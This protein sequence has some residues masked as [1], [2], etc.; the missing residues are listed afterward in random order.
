[1][2]SPL[3]NASLL[4]ASGKGSQAGEILEKFLKDNPVNFDA[5]ALLGVI[6]ATLGDPATAI[7]L[8]EKADRVRPGDAV[9]QNN[10]AR[11]C[12]QQDR[13]DEA[14]GY[15][16]RSLEIEPHNDAC[17]INLGNLLKNNDDLT[18]AANC[19]KRSLEI[20]PGNAWV[21]SNLG[22]VLAARG[23][24]DDAVAS[25]QRALEIDSSNALIHSNLGNAL[26]ALGR[27]DDAVAAHQ[28]ALEIDPGIA[29]IHNNLGS[30]LETQ[31]LLDE[32]VAS[33]RRALEINPDYANVSYNL[34]VVYNKL[35]RLDDA[36]ASYHRALAIKPD[37]APA[38]NNLGNVLQDLGR[39]DEGIFSLRKALAIKPDYAEAH[40][41]LHAHLLDPGDMTAAIKCMGKAV[42]IDPDRTDYRFFLGMLLDYSG[43][44]KEAETHFDRVENGENPDRARLDAWRYIKSAHKK[45]PPIIGNNIQ[46]FQLGLDAAVN[47][48]LVLEFGVRFGTSIR[49]IAALVDQEVHGFDSFEGLP[50]AWH[51]EPEGSYS[52]KG[53]IPSVQENV[54]LHQGWFEETLP[55]FIEKYPAPIRFINIDCDIYSSTKTVL[56]FLAK[57]ITPGTVIVFDEYIG[58]ENWR[59]DEFKACQ[60]AVLK[61][62]WKYEYLCFSFV[63]Q[64]VVVRIN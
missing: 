49:Q 57:Q 10:L 19:Y 38:H 6:R 8:F 37:F 36:V 11:I 53:I 30:A 63:T 15:Y 44:T 14:I 40:Y 4:F 47:D 54:I 18:G 24:H 5:L 41:N 45:L 35:G 9:I 46:A 12:E 29:S 42:H 60:E 13:F 61:Y 48:G 21:H 23:L 16:R 51:N 7:E 39:L 33:Y 28:R 2:S 52:T 27:L 20:N 58:N 64:Q 26:E 62:G 17:H 32:A 55:G 1:M 59:E 22:T 56:D 3:E 31:G 25:H 34:G 43:K 50:E